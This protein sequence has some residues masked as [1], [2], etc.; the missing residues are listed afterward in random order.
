MT[1]PKA[2]P[3]A[4]GNR[5]KA[6]RLQRNI[7]P[8]DLANQLGLSRQYIDYLESGSRMGSVDTV[9]KIAKFFEVDEDDM[10]AL[11]NERA[12]VA[13]PEHENS[14]PTLPDHI[15]HFVNLLY[16]I[17]EETCKKLLEQF[18]QDIH[19]KLYQL[20]PPFELREIKQWMVQ[21][22][23]IWYPLEGGDDVIDWAEKQGYFRE[24]GKEIFLTLHYDRVSFTVTLLQCDRKQI[25][26]LENILP[27]HDVSYVDD[28]TIPHLTQLQKVMRFIWFSPDTAAKDR[29]QYLQSKQVDFTSATLE[30]TEKQL[31]VLIKQ[32]SIKETV[33]NSSENGKENEQ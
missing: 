29:L 22:K 16:S 27:E 1:K 9:R 17:E 32:H 28:M 24:G 33:D 11:R 14:T 2:K 31:K 18:K 30:C 26:Y 23:R 25:R 5:I 21:I 20:L 8:K 15:D 19:Q 3:T 7:D 12:E 4:F 13:A 6:L 10:I